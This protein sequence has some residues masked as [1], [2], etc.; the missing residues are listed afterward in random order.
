MMRRTLL[1]FLLSLCLIHPAAAQTPEAA[2]WCVSVWFP[3][4]GDETGYSTLMAHTDLINVVNPWWYSPNPD[5]TLQPATHENAD[6]L[7]AWHI[8]GMTIIPTIFSNIWTMLGT[9]ETRAVHIQTILDLIE[10]SQTRLGTTYAGVDIDYEEFPLSIRDNLTTFIEDLSSALHERG[11]LLSVTVQAKADANGLTEHTAAQDWTR[12][13]PAADIFTI[14][15]YDYR[16]TRTEPGPI[17]PTPWVMDVLAYAQSVTDLSKVR[18]GLPFYGYVWTGGRPPARPAIWNNIERS[19]NNFH[20][21]VQRDP[22]DMEAHF[23]LKVPGLPRQVF[24]Y[25]D[26]TEL[27]FK[28]NAVQ[29]AYP[30]LGGVG[31]WGIGGEDPANWDVLSQ[32]K[33][34]ACVLPQNP[35]N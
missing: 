32:A 11:L 27:Q 31:I 5:G 16:G 7:A 2:S 15:T 29:A 17:A 8:A 19:V 24:Y 9:P 23:D 35:V 21:D 20:P 22:A 3:S 4:A 13:A 28:L 10:N 25:A 14:M 33:I 1:F 34:G 12:L 30:T 26:S 6:Q 18:M